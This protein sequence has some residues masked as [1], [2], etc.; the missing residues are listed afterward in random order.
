M[1]TGM[2][3]SILTEI[4][5]LL[6][7]L[8]ETGEPAA[9]DLRSLPLTTADRA[10]LEELL[11]RGEVSVSL[12]V[13]GRTEIWETGFSGVWWIRHMG[14]C[15]QVS[16]EEIAVTAIPDILRAHPVDIAAAADRLVNTL[17]THSK[18]SRIGH[19]EGKHV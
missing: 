17:E 2:A 18:D 11:G 7:Q 19:E 16:S 8:A 5:T 6:K 4:R 9:I 14:A 1:N 3:W 12:E 13:L 15:D 10:Q